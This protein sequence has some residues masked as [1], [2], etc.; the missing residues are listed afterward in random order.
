[1][2]Q[3]GFASASGELGGER[4]VAL[5]LLHQVRKL[6]FVVENQS[7]FAVCDQFR[8]AGFALDD[9]FAKVE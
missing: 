2:G 4:G 6:I 9:R 8:G 5:E 3:C 7:V 1:M